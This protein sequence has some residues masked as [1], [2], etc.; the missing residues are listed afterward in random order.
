MK[1][2]GEPPRE[3]YRAV[4]L[5]AP[6]NATMTLCREWAE[7]H[8]EAIGMLA[9]ILCAVTL[10]TILAVSF[11]VISARRD[12]PHHESVV[13]SSPLHQQ[14]STRINRSEPGSAI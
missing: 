9:S 3:A 13:A 5:S 8:W 14:S 2:F 7:E 10:S 11:N 12:Q 1:V 6:R 4:A